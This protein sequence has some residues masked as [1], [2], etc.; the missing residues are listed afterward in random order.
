MST[1]HSIETTTHGRFLVEAPEGDG[2]F[3]LLVGFHGYGENAAIHLDALRG[4]V[5]ARRWL[6]VSV[7]ALSRFYTRGDADVV[8]SWMTRQDREHAIADNIAYV[9]AV[10]A[11]VRREHATTGT[12]VY[13]GFSQGVA[14][15]YRAAGFAGV[16][17]S[18]LLLLAG[19]LPP[20]VAPSASALPPV[21]LGRGAADPWFT[22]ER[23]RKDLDQ[24]TAAGVSVNEH[25]FDAGHV[26]HPSFSERA[27]RF[28]DERLRA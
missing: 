10:V 1:A 14:M 9:G 24:L 16:S 3:P 11:R 22:E 2:P 28:L 19:D 13:A 21:L 25:V 17:A 6:T 27:G 15:A 18:G 23:A 8:A 26:W 4:V 7:Q 12:L 5:G 20:D